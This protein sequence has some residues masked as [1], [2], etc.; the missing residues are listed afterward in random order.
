MEITRVPVWRLWVLRA[1]Y[2]LIVIGMGMQIV[3]TL[4]QGGPWEYYEGVVNAMLLALVLLAAIGIFRPLAMLPLLFWEITWK[5]VWLISVA[6]PMAR[7][8]GLNDATLSNVFASAL[9]G[10]FVVAIPWRHAWRR[11][12]IGAQV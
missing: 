11:Y 3:P 1:C 4:L 2:G 5:A 10:I 9:A 12:V 7:G 8:P 6:L